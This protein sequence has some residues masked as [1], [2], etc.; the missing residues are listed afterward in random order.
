MQRAW[1]YF[2]TK[3][4]DTG[5]IQWSNGHDWPVYD[6]DRRVTRIIM[7]ARDTVAEDPD[8]VR[9]KAWARLH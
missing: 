6:A 7:T 4:W 1:L 2:A 5:E 8:A 3:G 9:R